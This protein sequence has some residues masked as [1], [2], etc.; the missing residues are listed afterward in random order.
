MVMPGGYTG[1]PATKDNRV[2]RFCAMGLPDPARNHPKL[3]R[4]CRDRVLRARFVNRDRFSG[5]CFSGSVG[6]L[7]GRFW[8]DCPVEL[9]V[10]STSM[11]AMLGCPGSG[12]PR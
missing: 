6:S 12:A 4:R 7:L 2:T 9:A 3:D 1:E 8:W 11:R 10:R 5:Q